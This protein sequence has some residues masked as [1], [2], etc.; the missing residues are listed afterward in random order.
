MSAHEISPILGTPGGTHCKKKR[1]EHSSGIRRALTC[2]LR[3]FARGFSE[4]LR[5]LSENSMRSQRDAR[6]RC[7]FSASMNGY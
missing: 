1:S 2:A 4:N 6:V 5:K 7:D 3:D